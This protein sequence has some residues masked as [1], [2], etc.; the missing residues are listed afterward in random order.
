[1]HR[2]FARHHGITIPRY[3]VHE[4]SKNIM[5]RRAAEVV[6]RWFLRGAHS[7]GLAFMQPRQVKPYRLVKRRQELGRHKAWP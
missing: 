5:K 4:S 1:M 6:C 7:N 2:R 3:I